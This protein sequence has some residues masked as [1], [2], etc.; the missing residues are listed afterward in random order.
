MLAVSGGCYS[1]SLEF[2]H[3]SLFPGQVTGF[4]FDVDRVNFQGWITQSRT[5]AFTGP[6]VHIRNHGPFHFDLKRDYDVKLPHIRVVEVT[7]QDSGGNILFT[8]VGR[9]DVFNN[10][11]LSSKNTIHIFPK[12]S[13]WKR[14]EPRDSSTD[15]WEHTQPVEVPW[16]VRK[17][18]LTVSYERAGPGPQ[19]TVHS[20]SIELHRCTKN[21]FGVTSDRVW[22]ATGGI[23]PPP[24]ELVDVY[25]DRAED[26]DSAKE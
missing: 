21:D 3:T 10:E 22:L 14:W 6:F 5:L 24:K 9:D 13:L 11:I 12:N 4:A 8:T 16:T 2:F 25:R 18:T 20:N 15:G 17:A 1:G 7:L 23:T 26:P 19:P